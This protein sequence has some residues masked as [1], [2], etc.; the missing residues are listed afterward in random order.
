MYCSTWNCVLVY[1]LLQVVLYYWLTF[2]HHF[3][4]AVCFLIQLI[5]RKRVHSSS[6]LFTFWILLLISSVIPLQSKI[7]Y[8]VTKTFRKGNFFVCYALMILRSDCYNVSVDWDIPR[9]MKGTPYCANIVSLD[10]DTVTKLRQKSL[11]TLHWHHMPLRWG[12]VI[13]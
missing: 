6:L 12:K 1:I 9:K 8:Q 11:L 13:Q 2:M 5:R 4:T 10:G 3:Q 7:S